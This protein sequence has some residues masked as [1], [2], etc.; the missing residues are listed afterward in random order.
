MVRWLT[1]LLDKHLKVR[2]LAAIGSNTHD[3]DIWE[4]VLN[5]SLCCFHLSGITSSDCYTEVS[6]EH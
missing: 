3:S 6:G 2:Q 4:L 1:Y 5:L